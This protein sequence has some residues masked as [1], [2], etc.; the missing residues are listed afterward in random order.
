MLLNADDRL[1]KGDM[2]AI[3]SGWDRSEGNLDF[4]IIILSE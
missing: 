2:F 3:K 4:E 1:F